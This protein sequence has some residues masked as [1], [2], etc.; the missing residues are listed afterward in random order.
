MGHRAPIGFN[1]LPRKSTTTVVGD[2]DGDHDREPHTQFIEYTLHRDKGRLGVQR[3]EDR[4]DE[5]DVDIAFDQASRLG[6][7]RFF[8][9]VEVD[10]PER[11]VFDL[12]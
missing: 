2:R 1:G 9:L 6:H 5:D 12:W 10:V 3:V 11:R 7:V 8:E 4:F